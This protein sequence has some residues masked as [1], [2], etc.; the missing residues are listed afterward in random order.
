MS[1]PKVHILLSTGSIHDCRTGH[2][3]TSDSILGAVNALFSAG[4]AIGSIVQG[5]ATD[6]L[7]RKKALAVAGIF[8]L[9]GAALVAGSVTISMLIVV[10]LLQG[11]GL[12][13]LICLIP[14]YTTEVAPPHRRGLLSGMT[15]MSFATGYFVYVTPWPPRKA[16]V[17]QSDETLTSFLSNS[18]ISF[19]TAYATNLTLAWRLPLALACVGPL[20]L[21]IGLP[22]IP[23]TP[24]YLSWLGKDDEAWAVIQKIHHDSQ[25][26]TD[27]VAR[28]EFIQITRQVAHDK[29]RKPGYLQML[30]QPSLRRR[31]LLV[32]F[33]L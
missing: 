22:F 20:L 28:V 14:L 24:R 33:L 23:E 15:T 32:M 12:G 17:C 3:L 5:W 2:R 1:Q 10:R 13:M 7:G 25:D 21:L 19:G 27:A 11:F 9:I 29:Q 6:W 30:T 8:S 4:L 16:V 26:P 18:W 31:S